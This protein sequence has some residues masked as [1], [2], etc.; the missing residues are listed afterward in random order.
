MIERIITAFF[1]FW[2]EIS[3]QDTKIEGILLTMVD[4]RENYARD[5]SL[6]VLLMMRTTNPHSKEQT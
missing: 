4:H 6:I 3:T 5:I 2:V 1:A